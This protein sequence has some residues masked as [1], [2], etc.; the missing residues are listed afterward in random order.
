[1]ED[2]VVVS[3]QQS[4]RRQEKSHCGCSRTFA[5]RATPICVHAAP[6]SGSSSIIQS[7]EHTLTAGLLLFSIKL[8]SVKEGVGGG[9]W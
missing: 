1:M 3:R 5:G 8:D 9:G 4:S 2:G 7:T 6:C